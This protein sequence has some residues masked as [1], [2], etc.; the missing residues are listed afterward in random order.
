M[1]K[2]QVSA[3]CSLHLTKI[4]KRKQTTLEFK[5]ECYPNDLTKK[6]TESTIITH[7]PKAL[8]GK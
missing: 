1:R 6:I 5:F 3:Q 8:K 4:S 7:S 2:Q